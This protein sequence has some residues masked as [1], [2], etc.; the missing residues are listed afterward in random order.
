MTSENIGGIIGILTTIGILYLLWK[1]SNKQVESFWKYF[2]HWKYIIFLL[3]IILFA[4]V[5]VVVPSSTD[6]SRGLPLLFL[7]ITIIAL[8]RYNTVFWK[9]AVM[10]ILYI[11][12][13]SGIYF[14]A[15]NVFYNMEDNA[16]IRIINNILKQNKNIPKMANENMQ[17]FKYSSKSSDSITM[18]FK[19][20]NHNKQSIIKEFINLNSF[21]EY[22]LKEELKSCATPNMREMLKYGLTMNIIYYD[23]NNDEISRI[24]I[25]NQACKLY[26]KN[27]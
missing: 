7:I 1:P 20:I 13:T 15:S 11:V 6:S 3:F 14:G 25:N 19:L 12:L 21:R 8:K 9:K 5:H 23:K 27:N 18:H 24:L 4:Y 16:N 22:M 10:F 17:I 2:F 26:Y